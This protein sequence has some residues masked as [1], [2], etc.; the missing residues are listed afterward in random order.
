MLNNICHMKWIAPI[1]RYDTNNIINNSNNN[2]IF[3]VNIIKK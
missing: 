2:N 1:Y 3:I